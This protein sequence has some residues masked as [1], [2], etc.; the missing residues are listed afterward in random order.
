MQGELAACC[1]LTIS[2]SNFMAEQLAFM[3]IC[4]QEE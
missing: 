2:T 1:H 3:L 4:M